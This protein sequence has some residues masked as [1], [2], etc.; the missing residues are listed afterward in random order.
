MG[1]EDEA[2]P[3]EGRARPIP[4]RDS[5]SAAPRS[6]LVPR[7]VS[8]VIGL[9]I[10]LA[11]IWFGGWFYAAG[12]TVAALWAATELFLMA[13]RA[14]FTPT[15]WIGL[16]GTA[17]LTLSPLFADRAP[18]SLGSLA[19]TLILIASLGQLVRRAGTS[20]RAFQEFLLTL[21]G[22]LYLGWLFSYLIWLRFLPEGRSLV[23][24][25]LLAT[26]AAD[27]AAY[28]IGRR[29]GKRKLAPA[30]SPNKTWEG[31]IGGLTIG[32]LAAL[33]LIWLL[34]LPFAWWPGLWLGCLMIL[35][36]QLGD[37]AE[38]AIKRGLQA[39]DAGALIPGH[40]GILDR[41][42]SLLLGAVVLYYTVRVLGMAP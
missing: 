29:W 33:A 7:L 3:P 30:V 2:A 40:G 11:L 5:V 32:A 9:P 27:T 42:D 23:A 15:W 21:S 19:L 34:A 6:A 41:A 1:T 8:A 36:G 28:G 18:V 24:L 22:T 37:L 12:I 39:K 35:A 38:S 4:A 31:A 13:R 17:A 25:L 10:L 26:F 20:P 14:G 16:P